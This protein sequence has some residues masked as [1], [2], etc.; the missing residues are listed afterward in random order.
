MNDDA[1]NRLRRRQHAEVENN[2]NLANPAGVIKLWRHLTVPIVNI[3]SFIW[4]LSVGR[5]ASY[6]YIS[7]HLR[8][9]FRVWVDF[10]GVMQ[11]TFQLLFSFIIPYCI[12]NVIIGTFWRVVSI[13][14]ERYACIILK[15]FSISIIIIFWY[16]FKIQWMVTNHALGFWENYHLHI[17]QPPPL[18]IENSHRRLNKAIDGGGRG[19]RRCRAKCLCKSR[20]KPSLFYYSS[21]K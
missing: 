2:S 16:K 19:I 10:V 20:Q 6:A 17:R 18:K 21:L 14:N 9:Y 15:T 8:F 1:P 13:M 3:R 7:L 4:S 5:G 11:I 12:K